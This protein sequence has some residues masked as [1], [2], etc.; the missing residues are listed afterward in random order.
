MRGGPGRRAGRGAGRR[1]VTDVEPAPTLGHRVRGAGG[2]APVLQWSLRATCRTRTGAGQLRAG[3]LRAGHRHPR[4]PS[5]ISSQTSGASRAAAS[6]VRQRPAER[7]LMANDLID[8]FHLLLTSVAAGSGHHL[9]REDPR[10]SATI[11]GRRQALRERRAGLGL[12]TPITRP[13]RTAALRHRA[14]AR[15]TEKRRPQLTPGVTPKAVMMRDGPLDLS[16]TRLPW[17]AYEFAVQVVNL[18]RFQAGTAVH[19]GPRSHLEREGWPVP[20][21]P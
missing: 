6:Q 9:F 17:Y 10:R 16:R 15:E 20:D 18:I 12:H 5:P 14:A 11:A 21:D 7:V 3:D 2:G 4:R 8:E 13:L 1:Q 19:L